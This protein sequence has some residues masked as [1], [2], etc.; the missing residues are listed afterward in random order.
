[1][2]HKLYKY[3]FY[4]F[5]VSILTFII[6]ITINS[7]IRRFVLHSAIN[8]YKVYMIVSVQEDLKRSKP[9]MFSAKKKVFKFIRVSNL[10]ANGK[11]KLLIGIYDVTK[12]IESRALSD[13]D[14]ILLEDLFYKITNIDPSMY[15]AKI[16]YAKSLFL[17]GEYQKSLNQINQA[18]KISPV[19]SEPYRLGIIVAK[20]IKNIKLADSFCKKYKVSHFGGME[21]RYKSN[22]FT[23]T[24]INKFAVQFT[25]LKSNKVYK[26]IYPSSGIELNKFIKHEIVPNIPL[27]IGGL[28]LYFTPIPGMKLEIKKII[29]QSDENNYELEKNEIFIFAK[30]SFFNNKNKYHSIFS[31]KTDDEIIDLNFKK[32]YINIDKIFIDMKLSKLELSS[33]SCPDL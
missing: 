24:N 6:L 5:F 4:L 23:G 32:K 14:Y 10:V 28:K 31:T 11:S 26:D 12:L 25:S 1:M 15:E 3:F 20:K 7:N 8:A 27:N 13:E 9:D 2:K 16:W 18:I 22:I 33:F 29:L 17:K 21:E 19:N 30:N